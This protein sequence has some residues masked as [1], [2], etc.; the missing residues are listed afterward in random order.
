MD[1][2]LGRVSIAQEADSGVDD[3]KYGVSLESAR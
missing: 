1:V 2:K 3:Y